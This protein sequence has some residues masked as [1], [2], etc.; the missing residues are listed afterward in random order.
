MPTDFKKAPKVDIEATAKFIENRNDVLR[1]EKEERL[2]YELSA[3]KVRT[4]ESKFARE[5]SFRMPEN[6]LSK[7][8]KDSSRNLKHVGTSE[9]SLGLTEKTQSDLP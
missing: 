7:I 3:A 2:A 6:K 8:N 9:G 5:P 1:R 4:N